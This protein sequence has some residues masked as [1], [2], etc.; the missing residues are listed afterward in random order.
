MYANSRLV[1]KFTV[2]ILAITLSDVFLCLTL[3]LGLL[4]SQLLIPTIHSPGI[5]IN[6]QLLPLWEEQTRWVSGQGVEM[7]FTE[8]PLNLGGIVDTTNVCMCVFS[9]LIK[10][11]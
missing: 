4:G 6:I 2:W 7:R 1:L 11:L 8:W 5:T 9:V 10:K 3:W